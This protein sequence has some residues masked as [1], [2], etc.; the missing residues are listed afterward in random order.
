[1]QSN[2]KSLQ[3]KL[4]ERQTEVKSKAEQLAQEEK[5][6]SSS[7]MVDRHQYSWREAISIH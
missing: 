5:V 6:A 2:R 3:G 7:P 1:M 4:Q